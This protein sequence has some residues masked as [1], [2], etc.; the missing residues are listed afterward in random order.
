MFLTLAPLRTFIDKR[1]YNCYAM[2]C[3]S[4][5]S[6]LKKHTLYTYLITGD[7]SDVD[8]CTKKFHKFL[9]Q[10]FPSIKFKK[11]DWYVFYFTDPE[12]EAFYILY[13]SNFN[14]ESCGCFDTKNDIN[15]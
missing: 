6:K 12:D 5:F 4:T 13:S 9:K 7:A 14:F 1:I 3:E 15:V 2:D 10:K 8:A 11:I